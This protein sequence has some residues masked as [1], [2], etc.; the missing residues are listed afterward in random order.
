VAQDFIVDRGLIDEL[1]SVASRAAAAILSFGPA[2]LARRDKADRSPV[3]AADEASDH[4]ILDGLRRLLPGVPVISEET[5]A[6]AGAAARGS[7]FLLV[8]PLDGTRE[9]LAG[10][11]EYTVNIALI[12]G[13]RPV[14]GVIAAPALGTIWTGL[15]GQGAER[16]RLAPG[17]EPA[18]ARERTAIRTRA[19]PRHGAIALLSR[20]H[21]DAETDAYLERLAPMERVVCGSAV[22][23]CR[24]AEGAADLYVRLS[25][26]SEW[27]AAAGH[28][29][30]T[31]AG[32]T[33]TTVDGSP[34]TYGRAGFRLPAF[35]V[36]GDGSASL[37]SPAY[38]GE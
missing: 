2:D 24:I 22:K 15:V 7:R 36:A 19:R 18:A 10:E 8:D 30:V 32:G 38:R 34:L 37:P 31:A 29:L 6:Q 33:V 4:V 35:I 13:G 17:A 21:R 5:A 25:S 3:T 9:L 12:D 16:L 1:A 27:D 23:F 26:L 20:F 11:A 28:A 14:A